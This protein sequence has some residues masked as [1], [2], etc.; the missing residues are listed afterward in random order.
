MNKDIIIK[1]TKK[2]ILSNIQS[3]FSKSHSGD[4][5]I[6][7]NQLVHKYVN[8]SLDYGGAY[9]FG[10]L[11][12]VIGFIVGFISYDISLFKDCTILAEEIDYIFLTTFSIA[13]ILGLC[14][15]LSDKL[16]PNKTDY[17]DIYFRESNGKVLIKSD[18]N[19]N[20]SIESEIMD[21][22]VLNYGE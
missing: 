1:D 7:E 6:D 4:L 8:K 2:N 22:L 10:G 12:I 18:Y 9:I 11:G 3:Y 20:D 21:F 14:G 15:L 5:S 13:F 17:L 16:S 19:N